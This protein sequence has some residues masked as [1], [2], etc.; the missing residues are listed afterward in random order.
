M[1]GCMITLTEE[2]ALCTLTANLLPMGD[3]LLV[4]LTG[5][6]AHIGSISTADAGGQH[7]QL[8]SGHRDDVLGLRF[9][10]ELQ[11]AFGGRV[12]VVCGV[13]VNT[14]SK[15]TLEAIIAMNERLLQR[16]IV[17]I[18]KSTF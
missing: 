9:A 3:D 7:N 2:S 10:M 1:G 11:G 4:S 16:C 6:E 15:E 5:G 14:P 13:H 18:K 12:T 17:E 8:F